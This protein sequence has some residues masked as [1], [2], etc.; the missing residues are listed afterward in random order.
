MTQGRILVWG[1]EGQAGRA[2][3]ELRAAHPGVE[4][5]VRPPAAEPGRDFDPGAYD[6][7][8]VVPD[9]ERCGPQEELTGRLR[10]AAPDTPVFVLCPEAFGPACAAHRSAAQSVAPTAHVVCIDR[11]VAALDRAV[12]ARADRRG[13]ERAER[14]YRDLFQNLPIGLFQRASDGAF[15][16]ANAAMAGI[17]GLPS[18]EA[19]LERRVQDFYL[20]PA[21][22]DRFEA[23]L[24]RDGVVIDRKLR[25]RRADGRPTWVLVSARAVRDEAGRLLYV[26]GATRSIDAR[27][28]AEA[29]R[30]K[31]EARYRTLAE[32]TRE[33][34]LIHDGERMFD[35]NRAAE[36]LFGLDREALLATRPL[37]LVHPED[38]E[39]VAARIRAGFW[40]EHE[41]RYVRSDGTTFWASLRVDPVEWEGRPVRMTLMQD[42]TPYRE[43]AE[44]ARAAERR[45]SNLMEAVP[46]GLVLL[47]SAG[48]VLAA[49]GAG[50]EL[51][52]A[53]GADPGRRVGALAGRPLVDL[54]TPGGEETELRT[55]GGDRRVMVS[56]HPI[57]SSSQGVLWALVLRD[58]TEEWLLREQAA[59]QD[60]LA[61]VG[62]LAAGIAHDFNNLL[63][64]ITGYAELA[65][66]DPGVSPKVQKRLEDLVKAAF[67]AAEL[68]RQMLDFSR[69]TGGERAPLNLVPV[70]KETAKMLDRTFPDEIRV[71]ARV[72]AAEAV[73]VGSA[74]EIE[75]VLMN[76]A[77]NARDAMPEGGTLTLGLR[78]RR[79]GDGP[80]WAEIEVADTGTGIP[81]EIRAKVFDPFFTTKPPGKGTGLGL[82]Q[83]ACI[84]DRHGGLVELESEPGRGT[85][86]RML[87]PLRPPR[88]KGERPKGPDLV[89]R[90]RGERVLVVDD[91]P[92][93]REI[94]A[95]LVESLG[96]ETELAADGAEALERVGAGGVDLVLSDVSMPRM[97]GPALV[98]ALGERGLRVPVVFL[99]GY[100][101]PEDLD[102]GIP[103]LRKPPTRLALAR[104][105]ARAIRGE[106]PLSN[107]GSEGEGAV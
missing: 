61:S 75:Q 71:E 21:D 35:A 22:R 39:T 29:A 15:L 50:R 56:S 74:L 97:N 31:S 40:G 6:A 59:Q 5:E 44:A 32:A 60:R 83:V 70:V 82:H 28:E 41:A 12:A 101:A 13:R 36:T 58:V 98:A 8:L 65:R 79:A 23:D 84:V 78:T 104:T 85:T 10:A 96:Y 42:V 52:A 67:R 2:A 25:L 62:Q 53:L 17:L 16:D 26:E 37:D 107:P 100:D 92:A 103:Y 3:E 80:G 99:S 43:A 105:L 69:G 93:V 87:L 18:R 51:L 55:P 11:V 106:P 90:G 94:T 9:P 19:L 47:D 7:V 77:V 81:E 27:V 46:V 34:L 66:L 63:L 89:P 30:D 73:V 102:P 1:D 20:D 91:D 4:T 33:A 49:N 86:V 57:E 48:G 95:A 54:L 14:R 68:V 45:L 88:D 38:R 76:L 72:E 24:A 64:A